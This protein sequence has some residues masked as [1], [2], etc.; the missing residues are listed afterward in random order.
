MC[1]PEN[2]TDTKKKDHPIKMSGA[3]ESTITYI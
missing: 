1:S 3:L 2:T